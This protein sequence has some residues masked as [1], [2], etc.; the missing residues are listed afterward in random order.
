MCIID[1]AL[2]QYTHLTNN[3]T[4]S[5][6]MKTSLTVIAGI[7]IMIFTANCYAD[8]ITFKFKLTGKLSNTSIKEL[9]PQSDSILSCKKS[10]DKFACEVDYTKISKGHPGNIM[11]STTFPGLYPMISL[12]NCNNPIFVGTQCVCT[13]TSS[14]GSI[15]VA[16]TSVRAKSF[17]VAID[18]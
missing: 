17:T 3:H 9:I 11:V 6:K 4:G 15:Q 18:R 8:L 7:L 13:A 1:L 10:Q 5:N 16:P 14:L 2:K 12:Q